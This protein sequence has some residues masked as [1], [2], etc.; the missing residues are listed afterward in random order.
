MQGN[1]TGDPPEFLFLDPPVDAAAAQCVIVVRRDFLHV[2][3]SIGASAVWLSNLYITRVVNENLTAV[4]A[5]DG[6]DLYMTAMTFVGTDDGGSRAIGLTPYSRLYIGRVFPALLA[7]TSCM[8]VGLK[9][10]IVF[11]E[12]VICMC[13]LGSAALLS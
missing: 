13:T 11:G 4:I 1:C 3:T 7:D 2:N 8:I 10:A 6:G 12:H 5:V 9:L